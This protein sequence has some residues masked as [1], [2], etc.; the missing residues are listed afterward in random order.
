MTHALVV[1]SNTTDALAMSLCAAEA[2]L[3]EV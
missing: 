3:R 1:Y 2:R